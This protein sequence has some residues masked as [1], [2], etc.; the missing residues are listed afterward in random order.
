MPSLT[1]V[2][3]EICPI[4]SNSTLREAVVASVYRKYA[5]ALTNYMCLTAL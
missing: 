4:A 3:T 2:I 5:G 1:M